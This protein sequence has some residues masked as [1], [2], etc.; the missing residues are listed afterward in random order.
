ME[1][2][3]GDRVSISAKKVGQPTR[4]GII[5]SVSKGLSGARYQVRWDDG[6]ETVL[7]PGAGNLTV[8]GRSKGNGK[9]ASAKKAP[10]KKK[11]SSKR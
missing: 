4:T 1:A 8:E 5:R 11:R 10:A 3:V 2:K 6:H 9:R 7:S